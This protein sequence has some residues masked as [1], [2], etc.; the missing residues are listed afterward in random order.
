M[1]SE[2]QDQNGNNLSNAMV[3]MD[4]VDVLLELG[5]QQEPEFDEKYPDEP[6]LVPIYVA[7]PR[8]EADFPNRIFFFLKI[9]VFNAISSFNLTT[10]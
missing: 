4:E 3:H 10:F 2:I 9:S 8:P 5:N 7:N 6:E 1:N